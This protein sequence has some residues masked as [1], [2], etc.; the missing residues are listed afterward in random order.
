MVSKAQGKS[1][2]K[3]IVERYGFVEKNDYLTKERLLSEQDIATKFVLPMLRALNWDP[4]QITEEGPE[5]HEKG[6][7]ERDINTSPQ[8]KVKRG[9][10][11]DFSL[12]RMGSD[13]PF[14]V[15]V[16]HPNLSLIPERDLKK[17]R[18][19]HL[20]L[21]TSFKKSMLIRVGKNRKKEVCKKFVADT[22]NLYVSKFANLWKYISNSNE[23]EGAR[24]AL[25]AWRHGQRALS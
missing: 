23:A 25:K 2:M 4:L 11:P 16:K 15:E 19:G 18:D 9:G 14:F 7:R 8:E 5:V 6:F 21:L 17:Y 3:K 10:L 1:M 24:S 22:P 12:Q 20:I 13:A